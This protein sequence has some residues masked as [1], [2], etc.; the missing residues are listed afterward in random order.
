M[1]GLNEQGFSLIEVLVAL[2][3][4]S[5]GMLGVA[6]L[7]A[8]STQ[9]GRTA[10]LQHQALLLAS[11]VAERI[12]ANPR[13]GVAYQGAHGSGSCAAENAVCDAQSMAGHD[14]AL[15]QRQ[16]AQTL[17]GGQVAVSV[18]DSRSPPTYAISVTWSE[19]GARTLPSHTI[20]VP[21]RQD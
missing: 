21:V 11:D 18:D 16:A 2:L 20:V 3:I 10:M 1:S 5:V 14:I 9:A 19:P 17:P 8:H 6:G 12:R 13:A 7:F 4:M 15:W